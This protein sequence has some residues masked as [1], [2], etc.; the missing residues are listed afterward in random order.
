MS[1][2]VTVYDKGDRSVRET[3]YFQTHVEAR[4]EKIKLEDQY[5]DADCVVEIEEVGSVWSP[6]PEDVTS[7]TQMRQLINDIRLNGL[8]LIHI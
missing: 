4:V 8:S 1:Y 3:H 5:R 7:A 2:T 6:A